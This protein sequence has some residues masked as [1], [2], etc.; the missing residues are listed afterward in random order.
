MYK[1]QEKEGIPSDQ[2]RLIFGFT[3]LFDVH[4]LSDYNIRYKATLRLMVLAGESMQLFI[5]PF[6]SGNTITLSV[7]TMQ[8]QSRYNVP[9]DQQRLIF[10][11]KQLE[12]GRTLFTYNIQRN[13]TFP[14]FI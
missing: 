2:Q 7:N 4:K 14:P 1:I 6:F 5:K 8:L 13:T 9:T 10:V 12:D 11:G 3:H